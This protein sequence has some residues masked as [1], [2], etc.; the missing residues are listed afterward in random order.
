MATA[1]GFAIGGF[2][3]IFAFIFLFSIAAMAFWIWMLVDC[4]QRKF[5]KEN[6]K[7]VWILVIVLTHWIGALI[8]YFMVKRK[9]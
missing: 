9:K 6:D 3:L 2:F 4:A 7:V 8:Y 1:E 5:K